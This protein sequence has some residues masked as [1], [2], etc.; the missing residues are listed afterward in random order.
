[1]LYWSNM[2]VTATVYQ[3]TVE[4]CDNDPYI[5]AFGYHIDPEDALSH[6]YV[7]ISRDLEQYLSAG[8]S[9]M[10]TGTGIY[11]GK[12]VVA[13]RMNRRWENRIDFLVNEDSFID[14]F[15]NVTITKCSEKN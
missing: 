2:S 5:T 3:A 1:M 8:D 11:D 6:R 10:V 9:V 14:I 15:P 7:A 13:D 12:W 4:Q